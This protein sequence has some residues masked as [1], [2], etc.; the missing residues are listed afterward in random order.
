MSERWTDKKTGFTGSV[1]SNATGL[2]FQRFLKESLGNIFTTKMTRTE[3]DGSSVIIKGH[4]KYEK[5][6]ASEKKEEVSGVSS[7]LLVLSETNIKEYLCGQDKYILKKTYPLNVAGTGIRSALSVNWSNKYNLPVVIWLRW[8][9]GVVNIR[10][11][12][13]TI[14]EDGTITRETQLPFSGLWEYSIVT[15]CD[16]V[17]AGEHYYIYATDSYFLRNAS[18][19][20][21]PDTLIAKIGDDFSFVSWEPTPANPSLKAVLRMGPES[22]FVPTQ[23]LFGPGTMDGY[24]NVFDWI[25]VSSSQSAYSIELGSVDP[26]RIWTEIRVPSG[27]GYTTIFSKDYSSPD[28]FRVFNSGCFCYL[29]YSGL[30]AVAGTENAVGKVY[31]LDRIGRLKYKITVPASRIAGIEK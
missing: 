12:I 5:I 2:S 15:F 7:S 23:P 1:P 26:A 21:F 4:G 8:D 17:K 30:Y 25:K 29:K 11:T 3:P 9:T 19:Y 31:I 28:L 13:S 16:K 14:E 10:A 27:G 24:A 18:T 20:N 22:Y 6:I